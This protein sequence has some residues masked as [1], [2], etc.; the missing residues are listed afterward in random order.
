MS[1]RTPVAPD[2]GDPLSMPSD[3]T[4]IQ[5]ALFSNPL[6]ALYRVRALVRYLADRGGYNAFL[7]IA[8]SRSMTVEMLEALTIVW[9]AAT[10]TWMRARARYHQGPTTVPHGAVSA[11][12]AIVHLW[13]DISSYRIASETIAHMTAITR[14]LMTGTELVSP[15]SWWGNIP[16]RPRVWCKREF[17]DIRDK[18]ASKFSAH[19]DQA[20]GMP[21][22]PQ[23]FRFG[24]AE[25]APGGTCVSAF[26]RINGMNTDCVFALPT[27]GDGLLNSQCVERWIECASPTDHGNHVSLESALG[28]VR[29]CRRAGA[30]KT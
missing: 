29:A 6:L 10:F 16:D 5:H 20:F 24:A 9:A 28:V 11:A 25:I 21:H 2:T 30:A 13:G 7:A 26:M 3:A 4:V 15:M 8:E 22:K 1:L 18:Y 12:S 14:M 23:G 27:T 17:W 19:C